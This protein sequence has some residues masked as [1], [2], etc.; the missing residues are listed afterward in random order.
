MKHN[1]LFAALI[2]DEFYWRHLMVH[3][4]RD[5]L[6]FLRTQARKNNCYALALRLI[7]G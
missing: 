3:G 4:G 1:K 5:Y 7:G 6:K 2:C